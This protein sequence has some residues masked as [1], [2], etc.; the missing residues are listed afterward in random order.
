[1]KKQILTLIALLVVLACSLTAV[2]N[3]SDITSA[4]YF[5][6]IRASNNST[7]TIKV[8]GVVSINGTA[9]IANGL[10]QSDASDIVIVDSGG[11]DTAFMP[12]V[13]DAVWPIWMASVPA[14]NQN[15]TL[16]T[17]ASGGKLRTFFN[18]SGMTVAD[19][20]PLE[21]SNNG[22]V[23]VSGYLDTSVAGCLVCKTASA[24]ISSDASGNVTARIMGATASTKYYPNGAGSNTSIASV[25]GAATHWQAVDEVSADDATTY[26]YTSSTFYQEDLYALSSQAAL[27]ESISSV[28]VTGRFRQNAANITAGSYFEPVL[29][30]NGVE[31]V[32]SPTTEQTATWTTVNTALAR[33]GGGNWSAADLL[34]LQAGAYLK[35]DHASYNAQL[36]QLNITITG[37]PVAASISASGLSSGEKT[38]SVGLVAPFLGIDTD[39]D[40]VLPVNDHLS[41][42]APLWQPE[43]NGTPFYTFDVTPIKLTVAGGATWSSSGYVFDGVDG[44]IYNTT[45]TPPTGAITIEFWYKST[46]GGQTGA[47]I[48]LH[49]STLYPFVAI[50][51]T[52]LQFYMNGSNDR[53]FTATLNDNA[54]HHIVV[55]LPGSAQTSI[56]T[57]TAYDNGSAL[58]VAS[59]VATGAQET[60]TN[61]IIGARSTAGNYPTK[62]T[63]GEVRFYSRVLSASEVLRNYNAT[64]WKYSGD[65]TQVKASVSANATVPDNSN[66][67]TFFT[68]N[69]MP[70]VQT[71][72]ITVNGTTAGSWDLS[73]W[74]NSTSIT[75]GSG[76]GNTGTANYRTTSSDSDVTMSLISFA[77]LST[78]EVDADT[79]IT[80]PTFADT[81][82]PPSAPDTTYTENA[83]PGLFF[84]PLVHAI[85]NGTGTNTYIPEAMFWYMF[86]FVQIIG[87]G[88]IIYWAFASNPEN[89]QQAL[90]IK[91]VIM[92]AIMTLFALPGPNIYG[93][94][95][96]V[97]SVMFNFGI[98]VLSKNYGW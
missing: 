83:S 51:S 35:V 65:T 24:N 85:W 93:L 76:N 3:A 64:L 66:N 23:S 26:V 13:G 88:I 90:F 81:A 46:A 72:N 96:V 78:A 49:S 29:S 61:T 57:A 19:N 44:R 62:A 28:N 92:T 31:T 87:G 70:Y 54:W 36:T 27:W 47:V 63:V 69:V 41:L 9:W 7:A 1:M 56:N 15:L 91:I 80:W 95:V 39:G 12:G 16:Y 32:G 77:P 59:T 48:G 84:A 94:Y 21:I 74:Y 53:L 8:S 86:A 60:R 89:R 55:T 43:S 33:P 37:V 42:N 40:I 2:A 34:T 82:N 71:A 20:T 50:T 75:D 4:V 22:T 18:N 14:G 38:I 17:G 58:T 97:Y 67:W 30:L 5:G 73:Q 79:A 11:S 25:F 52:Q 6:K 10:M 98:L 45:V 68:N